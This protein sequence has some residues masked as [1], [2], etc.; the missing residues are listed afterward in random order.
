MEKSLSQNKRVHGPTRY[1]E[2]QPTPLRRQIPYK[3][4]KTGIQRMLQKISTELLQK[5]QLRKTWKSTTSQ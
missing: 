1:T 4:D 3:N 5:K 2:I